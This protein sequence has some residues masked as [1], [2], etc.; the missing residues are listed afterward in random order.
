MHIMYTYVDVRR[1]RH[2]QLWD[3]TLETVC[4][5]AVISLLTFAWRQRKRIVVNKKVNRVRA[6]HLL[7]TKFVLGM[8]TFEFDGR[9]SFPL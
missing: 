1:T 8:Q 6:V 5:R 2:A 3:R 4:A 7:E 9:T